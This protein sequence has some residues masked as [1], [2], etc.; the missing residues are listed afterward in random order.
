MRSARVTINVRR[1]PTIERCYLTRSHAT[2]ITRVFVSANPSVR[3]WRQKNSK[4]STKV[5][6][7]IYQDFS[8]TELLVGWPLLRAISYLGERDHDVRQL[9]WYN[10]ILTNK[11]L[12]QQ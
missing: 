3:E 7:T 12:S 9:Q 11:S 4:S 10:C 6:R 1:R 8:A 2:F 5:N